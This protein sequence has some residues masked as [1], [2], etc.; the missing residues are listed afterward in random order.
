MQNT[1]RTNKHVFAGGLRVFVSLQLQQKRLTTYSSYHVKSCDD[2]DV[3][4][5]IS[6]LLYSL[7]VHAARTSLT[8]YHIGL[9]YPAL[10]SYENVPER[11]LR[12]AP[13]L[14]LRLC[15]SHRFLDKCGQMVSLWTL[16]LL[17]AAGHRRAEGLL[18]G[19]R[20]AA[21]PT[22]A[23]WQGIHAVAAT[24]AATAT[25]RDRGSSRSVCRMAEGEASQVAAPSSSS[26]VADEIVGLA[27]VRHLA[28]EG[29][30]PSSAAE[31]TAGS[32]DE[33]VDGSTQAPVEAVAA[34]SSEDVEAGN[35]NSVVVSQE[36]DNAPID[37]ILSRRLPINSRRFYRKALEAGDVKLDGKVVRRF[38]R[39][40]AGSKIAVKMVG[41]SVAADT[42][43]RNFLF[44]QRL[45]GLRVLYEDEHFVA[46]MK[47]AGMVCQPC[48]AAA[49]GTVLHGLLY[50]MVQT[51]Q[52][53]EGDLAAA[54]TLSQG[55]VQRLDKHT[56]GI[57][58]VAKVLADCTTG[59][60][61]A[62]Q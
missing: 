21:T 13:P 45:P 40:K 20:A 9:E 34:P 43:P 38:V 51:K 25:S 4:C 54:R 2:D 22:S 52:V 16:V 62:L 55:I 27:R 19:P 44:P 61:V 32:H 58:V 1:N 37:W 36:D 46:I 10:T 26:S 48:E 41:G 17:V 50:H 7:A 5:V 12:N 57:M 6:V 14:R 39:V 53:A 59:V 28:T 3:C 15:K 31:P 18:V 11:S 56:S 33:I 35:K 30:A 23:R 60:H 42:T 29:S 8:L 24:A 47:P 49:S